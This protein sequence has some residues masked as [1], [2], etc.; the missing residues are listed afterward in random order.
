MNIRETA[1]KHKLD[2]III[3]SLLLVGLI[4]L[5]L[6]LCLGQKSNL[7]AT[8]KV[9]NSVIETVDLSKENDERD[10]T[11]K[12]K[13]SDMTFTVKKDAI[14]VKESDCKTH[15][16]VHQGYITSTSQTIICAYNQ[17]VVTLS[18][19]SSSIDVEI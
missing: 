12:G 15:Y 19:K 9:G 17:V 3:S 6:V 11:I 1:K 13:V 18:G 16:C 2:I 4:A 10:F 7:I 8:I 5:T 14:K